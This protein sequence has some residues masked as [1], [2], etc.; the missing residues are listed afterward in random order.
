[1]RPRLLRIAGIAE[2][3]IQGGDRKQ[4]QVLFD[5]AALVDYDVSLSEV[6]QAISNSNVN[7]SGGFAVEGE[8]ERPIRIFGR[9]GPDPARAETPKQVQ[10]KPAV[11][12]QPPKQAQAPS[13]VAVQAT[14]QP[15]SRSGSWLPMALAPADKPIAKQPAARLSGPAYS[16][17]VWSALAR[18]K[19]RA[20]QIG[21]ARVSAA[22]RSDST[23]TGPAAW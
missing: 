2:V 23:S 4:Y 5:P 21:S 7:S 19:P 1:V 20:G 18:H 13:A 9:R 11:T 8:T 12:Q 14:G 6:E 16:S 17:K 15:S 22:A 3:F 10:A